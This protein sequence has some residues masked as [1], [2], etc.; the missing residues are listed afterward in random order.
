MR[1]ITQNKQYLPHEIKTKVN[2]MKL[3]RQTKDISFVCR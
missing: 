1:Y 3:Y 2:S